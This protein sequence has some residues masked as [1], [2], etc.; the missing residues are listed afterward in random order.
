MYKDKNANSFDII[1]NLE[2]NDLKALNGK[3]LEAGI[4][5]KY[6]FISVVLLDNLNNVTKKF[7]TNL[8]I[9]NRFSTSETNWEEFSTRILDFY[10]SDKNIFKYN[11]CF[12]SDYEG[13]NAL[14]RGVHY[15]LQEENINSL[16]KEMNNLKE[17]LSSLNPNFSGATPK[18]K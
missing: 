10:K 9:G 8:S 6:D 4:I 16:E 5:N 17:V 3:F 14:T 11:L 18:I 13:S 2:E 15:E 7:Q 1:K 12:Y